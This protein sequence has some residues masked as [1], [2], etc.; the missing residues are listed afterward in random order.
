MEISLVSFSCYSS[1]EALPAILK[2]LRILT[3]NIFWSLFLLKLEFLDYRFCNVKKKGT[4]F[5]KVFFGF[6]EFLEQPLLSEHFQKIIF[7]EVYAEVDLEGGTGG[8]RGS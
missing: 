3:G 7:S 4:I 8:H 2:I 6:F 5:A 1:A